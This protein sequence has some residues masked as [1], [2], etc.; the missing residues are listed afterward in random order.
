MTHIFQ[1]WDNEKFKNVLYLIFR[2][3]L[4]A[5]FVY[6]SLDKIWNPGQFANSIANYKLLPLPLLHLAAIILPWLEILCGMLLI[7][8]YKARTANI[9]IGSMLIVFTLAILISMARGLDFN[10]G[11]YAQ[12]DT[13]SNIGLGKVLNNIQLIIVSVILELRFRR[14]Q[15]AEQ[16]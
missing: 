10:C 12:D 13:R 6:A 2:V 3:G 15:K 9:L 4:G 16:N 7:F 14:L 11:C 1:N 5:L 8:N